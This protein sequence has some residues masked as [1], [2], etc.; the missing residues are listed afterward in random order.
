M[1]WSSSQVSGQVSGV[2][3]G[4]VGW[5][6]GLLSV[7]PAWVPSDRVAASLSRSRTLSGAFSWSASGSRDTACS[8][9]ALP[10]AA[11]R[12]T[13]IHFLSY[14][15]LLYFSFSY[16]FSFYYFRFLLFLSLVKLEENFIHS[17]ELDNLFCSFKNWLYQAVENKVYVPSSF[18]VKMSYFKKI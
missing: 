9:V 1:E 8:S 17:G 12:T 4:S 7:E 2:R 10:P 3:V 16:L 18:S 15:Q 6:A 14:M 11:Q 13:T 5:V